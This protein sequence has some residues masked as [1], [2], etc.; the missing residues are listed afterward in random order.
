MAHHRPHTGR[1]TSVT[2]DDNTRDVLLAVEAEPTTST[3]RLSAEFNISQSSVCRILKKENIHPYKPVYSQE[4]VDGD[5]D[6]RSQFC[7]MMHEHM[8]RDPAFIRK[9][10]FSDE[11]VFHLDGTVNKHNVHFW[12]RENPHERIFHRG[13][14]V[15]LTVWA[16]MSFNGELFYD[17]NRATMNGERYE[18]ILTDHVVP[19]FYRH[20]E[21]FFSR[22]A[23]LAIMLHKCDAFWMNSFQV[24]GLVVAGQSN[25]LQDH[26]T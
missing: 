14:T 26:P 8:Q 13:K 18:T 20:R 6:R 24:D 7:E 10:T 21:L 3:R 23:L 19:H 11:C 16:C 9:L 25:G 12:S 2:G 22:M 15:S 17:I 5:D 4:L 1:K